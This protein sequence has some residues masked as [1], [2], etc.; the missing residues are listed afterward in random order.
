LLSQILP[1]RCL[2]FILLVDIL[3]CLGCF[4]LHPSPEES[5][6]FIVWDILGIEIRR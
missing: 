5:P 1:Y 3:H 6:F 4:A 2:S